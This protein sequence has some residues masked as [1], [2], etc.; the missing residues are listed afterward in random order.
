MGPCYGAPVESAGM[1][2]GLFYG[3]LFGKKMYIH[4]YIYIYIYVQI[5]MRIPDWESM[6]RRVERGN[7]LAYRSGSYACYLKR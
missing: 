7:D 6:V 2:R 4:I 5:N 1:L 3:P